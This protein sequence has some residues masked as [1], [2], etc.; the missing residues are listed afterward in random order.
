MKS[1]LKAG[2][3][4]LKAIIFFGIM[5]TVMLVQEVQ[6]PVTFVNDSMLF[7]LNLIEM[8]WMHDKVKEQNMILMV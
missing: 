3:R 8:K 6:F 2:T 1:K 5:D 7:K 4:L